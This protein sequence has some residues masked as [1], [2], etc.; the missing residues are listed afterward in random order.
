[1]YDF[2]GQLLLPQKNFTVHKSTVKELV[3]YLLGNMCLIDKL[4]Y[5]PYVQFNEYFIYLLGMPYREYAAIIKTYGSTTNISST[6]LEEVKILY[7]EYKEEIS[8]E[9]KN[10]MFSDDL[11]K[12][13]LRVVSN[14]TTHQVSKA[15]ALR[16]IYLAKIE[17]YD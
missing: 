17:L 6:A 14:N 7:D 2:S 5:Y 11:T 13:V 12:K 8:F 15:L 10:F 16:L 9:V 1:M 3:T 4:Q